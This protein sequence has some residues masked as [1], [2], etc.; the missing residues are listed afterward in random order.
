[1][2]GSLTY[3]NLN[4]NNL[5]WNIPSYLNTFTVLNNLELSYNSL[6]G[7]IPDLSTL[8]TWAQIYLN[9]NLSWTV[10]SFSGSNL[11][12]YVDV[13]E[14]NLNFAD[15]E[16]NLSTNLT[17]STFN[18]ESQQN[19]GL[20]WSLV[21]SG[22]PLIITSVLAEDTDNHYVW[23]KDWNSISWQTGS[24]LSV[25]APWV[26]TYQVTNDNV[27]WLTLI[28]NP[29]TV[30]EALPVIN[31]STNPTS[32]DA[33]TYMIEW[34]VT[35]YTWWIQL[36]T[37][38]WAT[39][40]VMPSNWIFKERVP[41]EQNIANTITINAWNNSWNTGSTSVV[42]TE[43]GALDDFTWALE[44]E[45]SSD[46]Y[47]TTTVYWTGITS[48]TWVV[49]DQ[50]VKFTTW[51]VVVSIPS[52]TEITRTDWSTF[53]A[54]ELGSEPATVTGWLGTNES[55]LWAM[56]FGL[57]LSSLG[58]NFSK[59]IKV[60]FP[61]SWITNWTVTVKVKHG[62]TSTFV[63]TWLTNDPNATCSGWL[64]SISSNI[65][66]VSSGI[67][68]IYTCSASIF[69]AYSTSSSSWGGGGSGWLSIDYCPTWDTS[70]NYYDKKCSKDL[71][72]TWTINTGSVLVYLNNKVYKN[73]KVN[74]VKEMLDKKIKKYSKQQELLN[75]LSIKFLEKLDFYLSNKKILNKEKIT[76]LKKEILSIYY[77]ILSLLKNWKYKS[78]NDKINK[79]IVKLDKKN[80]T[81]SKEF[82]Y[83]RNLF[84]YKL[85]YFVI[86]K[87]KPTKTEKQEL[88]E[89]Y[90]KLFK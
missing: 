6:T 50:P 5:N 44:I 19:I 53:D 42:I 52:D 27:A 78:D 13:R 74:K 58:I 60:S 63:T 39:I 56:E 34:V 90:K 85:E 71:T 73:S 1:M 77:N 12:E 82:I 55:S 86:N 31:L 41:L 25:T 47:Y 30:T 2:S 68:T 7:S 40:N 67:V 48:A 43:S 16:P 14:N 28:S 80:K 20:T 46:F 66:T 9:N 37:N 29:I 89:L 65:A 59:P 64:A 38:T 57:S 10:P 76:L 51:S 26:Y 70:G 49:F 81:N 17:I 79:L 18:Y 32:V 22:T 72:L 23:E 36:V 45:D 15:L 21:Y 11:I 33:D 88:L 24:S 69:T 61:V 4:N 3:L 35:S 83:N 54:T 84:I 87:I 8:G 62:G 75:I